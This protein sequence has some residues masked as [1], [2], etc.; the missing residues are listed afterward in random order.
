MKKALLLIVAGILSQSC[1]KEAKTF[2]FEC[3]T[4]T[5]TNS[6]GS[7]PTVTQ[8]SSTLC[9]KTDAQIQEYQKSGTKTISQ[10]GYNYF[11]LVTCKKK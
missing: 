5:T 9:D 8:S 2:C 6:A 11:F 7:S 1:T 4:K 10:N 3:T